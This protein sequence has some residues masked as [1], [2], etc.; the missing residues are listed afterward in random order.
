MIFVLNDVE[1]FENFKDRN[2]FERSVQLTLS[3]LLM[4]ELRE[5]ERE[6]EGKGFEQ[7]NHRDAVSYETDEIFVQT[8]RTIFI[9]NQFILHN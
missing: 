7:K 8:L 1:L 9:L 3:R 4:F 2:Q 6:G 5:L